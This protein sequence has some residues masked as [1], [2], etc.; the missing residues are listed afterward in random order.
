MTNP[1][2]ATRQK[3][4]Y[5]VQYWTDEPEVMRWDGK[6]WRDK[7]GDEIVGTVCGMFVDESRLE[8]PTPAA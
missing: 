7:D 1:N 6:H 8:P 3:G 5:L 4:Y 2:D